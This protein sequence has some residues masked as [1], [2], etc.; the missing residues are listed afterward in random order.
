VAHEPFIATGG[1]AGDPG[2]RL[3]LLAPALFV[4]LWSTG[5]IAAKFGLPYAPPLTFLLYRFVLV[6]ALMAVV[7]ALTGARWPSRRADYLNVAIAA[8]LVHGVYLGGVFVAMSRGMAAGTAAMLVGLQPIVTVFLARVWLHEPVIARQWFGLVL[9][10][11]GVWL[12]VRQKIRVDSDAIALVAVF[13]ALVGISVGTIW[14]KRHAS[15]ID[16]RSGAVIQFAACAI[17]YVPLV[18]LFESTQRVAWT[19]TFAFAMGWSVLV[20]SVGAISLLYWLLRHGAASGVAR[21]FYL[22]PPV[23]ALMAWALFDERMDML[24]IAGMVLIAIAVALA[25]PRA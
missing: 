25:R 22:V 2:M 8:W 3:L 24:A 10:L 1:R 17:A 19:A 11:F 15:H 18:L 12:V 6:A 23:T 5:F 21:L 9:G 20:L 13:A 4:L 14:Q 7:C 16:L